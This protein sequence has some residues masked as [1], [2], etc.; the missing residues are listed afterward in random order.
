MII[1]K[2]ILKTDQDMKIDTEKKILDITIEMN[3]IRIIVMNMIEVSMTAM[4][5]R[6]LGTENT[7]IRITIIHLTIILKLQIFNQSK[8]LIYSNRLQNMAFIII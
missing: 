2:V 4:Q 8:H 6:I 7:M 3:I 5:S 1:D